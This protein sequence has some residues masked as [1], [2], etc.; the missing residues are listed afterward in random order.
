MKRGIIDFVYLSSTLIYPR[1]RVIKD[2]GTIMNTK[3]YSTEIINK[4][5]NYYYFDLLKQ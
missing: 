2:K 4:T 1:L 5:V 3:R